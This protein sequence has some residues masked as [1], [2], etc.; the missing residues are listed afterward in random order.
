MAEWIYTSHCAQTEIF[1]HSKL[2]INNVRVIHDGCQQQD[3]RS[4]A[5]H[6]GGCGYCRD[7]ARH[8][9]TRR[10][11]ARWHFGRG[12]G[13]RHIFIKHSQILIQNMLY[14]FC[15]KCYRA[16]FAAENILSHFLFDIPVLRVL[17][18]HISKRRHIF[19][20]VNNCFE[21]IPKYCFL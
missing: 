8:G 15:L 20:Y 7:T 12:C 1:F 13:P 17:S 19:V 9:A 21:I 16:V 6:R 3:A 10:G 5:C 11:T 14:S 18:S 2:Y 4:A